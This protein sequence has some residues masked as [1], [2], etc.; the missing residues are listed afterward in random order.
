MRNALV[1][2]LDVIVTFQNGANQTLSL[3][4][5]IVTF[6]DGVDLEPTDNL[7]SRFFALAKCIGRPGSHRRLYLIN[8]ID[9][10]SARIL[11]AKIAGTYTSE[12]VI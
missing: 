3:L 7:F 12:H 8:L 11:S 6:P 9:C 2:T 10:K 1:G 5:A 4:V